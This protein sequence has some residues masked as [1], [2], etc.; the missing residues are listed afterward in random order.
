MWPQ[1]MAVAWVV[2]TSDMQTRQDVVPLEP[3]AAAAAYAAASSDCDSS[4]ARLYT[5]SWPRSAMVPAARQSGGAQK[6]QLSGVGWGR[7]P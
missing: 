7:Q 1:S 4:P 6:C 5:S 3:V 2:G